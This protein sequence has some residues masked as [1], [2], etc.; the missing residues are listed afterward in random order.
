MHEFLPQ[1]RQELLDAT[2]W[3]LVDGGE[4]VAEEFEWAVQPALRLRD[5]GVGLE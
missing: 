3:Y 4:P 2:R 1:A 5:A